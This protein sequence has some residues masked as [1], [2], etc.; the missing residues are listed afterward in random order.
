MFIYGL[1]V[2]LDCGF[3]EGGFWFFVGRG[4]FAFRRRDSIGVFYWR[5][6]NGLFFRF[7]IFGFV[8]FD[9]F[10]SFSVFVCKTSVIVFF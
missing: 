6:W 3:C 1:F 4:F 9:Y 5:E 2:L 8:S 7:G 10:L